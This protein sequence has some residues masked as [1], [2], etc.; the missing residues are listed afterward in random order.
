MYAIYFLTFRKKSSVY[1]QREGKWNRTIKQ[2]EIWVE[3]ALYYSG[4]FSVSWELF[5]SE[6]FYKMTHDPAP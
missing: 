2:G 3:H 4:S 1:G 5:S 6:K